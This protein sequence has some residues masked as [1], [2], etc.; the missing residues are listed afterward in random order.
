[1]RHLARGSVVG[2]TPSQVKHLIGRPDHA[3]SVSGQVI[4]CYDLQNNSYQLVFANGVVSQ[5]NHY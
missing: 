3:Q 4:C 2:K 1:M 5:Q